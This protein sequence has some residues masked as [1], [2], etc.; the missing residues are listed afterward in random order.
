MINICRSVFLATLVLAVSACTA[1]EEISSHPLSFMCLKDS[2]TYLNGVDWK[3]AGIVNI[4]YQ[5]GRYSPL[6]TS[7][8][9]KK[10]YILRITNKD[11]KI[12]GF[13]A[14]EL[15]R[16]VALSM[17]VNGGDISTRSCPIGLN[18]APGNTSEVRLV[19]VDEGGYYF[20]DD[21]IVGGI[22]LDSLSPRA[23]AKAVFSTLEPEKKLFFNED[24]DVGSGGPE[25][26]FGIIAVE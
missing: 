7:L 22:L 2:A 8:E 4:T 26:A 16:S 1:K 14:G 5:N 25:I 13:R 9:S 19:A 20:R 18:I 6:V 21:P 24:K 17:V 23:A 15:F 3:K 12:R 11:K 10:P